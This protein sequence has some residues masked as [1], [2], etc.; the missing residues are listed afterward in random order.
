MSQT[1]NNRF[2]GINMPEAAIV[3]GVITTENTTPVVAAG[4][5][6]TVAKNG[7]GRYKI[8]FN[9]VFPK[10]VSAVGQY[11]SAAGTA[12]LLKKIKYTAGD[13]FIE[14]L[15]E[16]TSG[17]AAEPGATD[18]LEFIAVVMTASLPLT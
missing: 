9:Q 17:V 14:F 5:G 15:F 1:V 7:T 3:A 4:R 6:F 10:I 13:N 2:A 11:S 18:Q 8:T 12:R 16:N